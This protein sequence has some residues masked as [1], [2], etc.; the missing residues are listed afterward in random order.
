[1]VRELRASKLDPLPFLELKLFDGFVFICHQKLL[2]HWAL[3]IQGLCDELQLALGV[4]DVTRDAQRIIAELAG[5]HCQ[6]G[7]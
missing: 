2:K 3:L 5:R 1:M 7:V 6:L 4:P